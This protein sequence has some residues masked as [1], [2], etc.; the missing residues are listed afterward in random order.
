MT[1]RWDE[2]PACLVL[3]CLLASCFLLCVWHFG[4][5]LLVSFPCCRLSPPVCCWMLRAYS[6]H[7]GPFP[8]C[9][10]ICLLRDRVCLNH[11]HLDLSVLISSGLDARHA[12]RPHRCHR[13]QQR[14][15]QAAVFVFVI[16]TCSRFSLSPPDCL[17]RSVFL[18]ELFRVSPYA[19]PT[20]LCPL[21]ILAES[22]N[23]LAFLYSSLN[24]DDW[25]Y[26]L[27]LLSSS[28]SLL[29]SH[30]QHAER[31]CPSNHG[32]GRQDGLAPRPPRQQPGAK[33]P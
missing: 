6:D 19:R 26:F 12:P 5:A 31:H 33:V 9:C 22:S 1:S 13:E 17:F 15:R 29:R 2:T 27:L 28:S 21:P 10:W 18:L 23:F 20:T 16:L 3:S 11:T 14:R 24:N 25:S 7:V 32:N 8:F 30:R 4:L